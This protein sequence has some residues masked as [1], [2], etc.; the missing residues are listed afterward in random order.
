VEFGG[1]GKGNLL[2]LVNKKK[3]RKVAFFHSGRISK[4]LQIY[5]FVVIFL[6]LYY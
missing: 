4:L 6:E 5:L 3:K 1:T 2:S